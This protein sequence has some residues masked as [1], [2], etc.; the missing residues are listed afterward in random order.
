[1]SPNQLTVFVVT[2]LLLFTAWGNAWALL[3]FSLSGLAIMLLQT[4]KG[5]PRT[6]GTQLLAAGVACGCAVALV[7]LS[8]A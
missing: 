8:L 6:F 3:A 5:Q 1:M 7:I 4:S 2:G